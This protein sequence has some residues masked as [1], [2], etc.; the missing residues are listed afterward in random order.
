MMRNAK[1]SMERLVACHLAVR[2]TAM[3]LPKNA[4]FNPYL[5]VHDATLYLVVI[6]QIVKRISIAL[7]QVAERALKARFANINQPQICAVLA[8]LRVARTA[9]NFIYLR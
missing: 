4:C 8:Q 3:Y 6:A 2:C 9:T 5:T 7:K 1:S